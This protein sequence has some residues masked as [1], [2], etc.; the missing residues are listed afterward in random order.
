MKQQRGAN[1]CT[2]TNAKGNPPTA[3]IHPRSVVPKE[4]V[5][6]GDAPPPRGIVV[7][8]ALSVCL[9]VAFSV[10]SLCV[11]VVRLAG[12]GRVPTRFFCWWIAWSPASFV[13]SQAKFRAKSLDS[14]IAHPHHLLS[15]RGE[16]RKRKKKRNCTSRLR[17]PKVRLIQPG[18]EPGSGA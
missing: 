5:S 2:E 1:R 17:L 7:D 6:L 16:K 14:T 18:F 12:Y 15:K 10:H 13:E 4:V 8:V 9:R 11:F 3:P